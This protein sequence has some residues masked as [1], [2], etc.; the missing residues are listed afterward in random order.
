MTSTFINTS[1]RACLFDAR[2]PSNQTAIDH[3][4]TLRNSRSRII[5]SN[6]VIA[7]LIALFDSPLRL[8][9][10][11][12]FTTIDPKNHSLELKS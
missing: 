3:F 1:G 9:R 2:Q 6:Y 5:T 7:E 10:S 8:P 4:K 12:I 11:T